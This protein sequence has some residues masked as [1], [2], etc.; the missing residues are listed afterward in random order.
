[1]VCRKNSTGCGGFN[2]FV[3]ENACF[4]LRKSDISVANFVFV[5]CLEN[6]PP[7]VLY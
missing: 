1:M 2:L 4:H 5:D 7:A 3:A 6:I